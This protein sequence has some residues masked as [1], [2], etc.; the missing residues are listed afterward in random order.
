[1]I[2]ITG[3]SKQF[4]RFDAIRGLTLSVP[5]GSAF[6]LIGANGAGKTTTIKT[7]MNL[8]QP[9]RGSIRVM[10]VESLR[11]AA[12]DY[13]RIGYVSENQDLPE[14]LRVRQFLSFLRPL[15][16]TWDTDL[17][18]TLVTQTQL[19]RERRIGD[20]SHGMRSKL[21]LI[22][23][24]SF[25]P[26]LLVFDEP[27][28]GLDPLARDEFM[29][30]L[31]RHRGQT[32]LLI[33]SHDLG[34]IED[35][36][37][38]IAFIDRGSVLFQESMAE[39]VARVREVRIITDSGFP[40]LRA[41]PDGWLRFEQAGEAITFID[42]QFRAAGFEDRVRAVLGPV[43]NVDV[44]PIKLRAIFTAIARSIKHEGAR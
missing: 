24:L 17:E 16:P 22:C 13:A 36:A 41:T 33:S 32:T 20:L 6:V 21:A 1:M 9:D 4:G 29:A 37:T 14:R 43:R 5:A 8:I 19:P 35:I 11:L 40:P 26:K 18:A 2:E 15:Y 12:S 34:E 42:T 27:F 39:L 7:L 31:S 3:L 25:H 28:S 30:I 38:H 44:R 23:A 10:G